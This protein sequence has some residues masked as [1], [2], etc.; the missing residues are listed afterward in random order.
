MIIDFYKY[1]GTG[2]DFILIDNREGKVILKEEQVKFL[3]DR[4]FGVGADGLMLIQN[5]SGYDFEMIYYNS[6]GKEGSMCG[7]GG[8]C[9]TAFARKLGIIGTEAKFIATDGEHLANILYENGDEILVQL[10]MQ[11]VDSIQKDGQN[12]FLNTGSPH[13]IVFEE[14]VASLDVYTKGKEIRYSSLF[15][16][17]G[18]TNVNFV[19]E[20]KSYLYV[21]TYE[22]GVE[23]ETF[24]CGTGVT[25]SAL[26]YALDKDIH[27]VNVKTKGGNL[28]IRFQQM[29]GRFFDIWL[30]ANVNFV[31]QGKISI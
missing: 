27:E 19:E 2:N 30:E 8:R 5:K 29:N 21:R 24:S 1:Q 12:F 13:Y 16:E 11:N 6:D 28:H 9:I 14:G 4:R 23:D 17:I 18:G 10:A 26:S 3:C 25:A 15:K 7:N 22:R 31:F 20:F